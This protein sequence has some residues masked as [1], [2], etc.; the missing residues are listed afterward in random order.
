MKILLV[1][2]LY[3]RHDLS[4]II[5]PYYNKFDI[6]KLAVGSEGNVSREVAESSGWNYFESLNSPLTFKFTSLFQKAREYAPDAVLLMG[7]DDL[8]SER[9]I[10]YYQDNYSAEAK[11]LMGLKDLYFYHSRTG[12][13]IQHQ[14]FIGTKSPFTIGCG[15]IFS[16]ALLDTIDWKPWGEQRTERGL[17]ITCSRIFERIGV[18]E[19]QLTMDEAGMA[20]DIKTDVGLTKME[21]FNFNF[22]NVSAEII[23]KEFPEQLQ[24]I[25]NLYLHNDTRSLN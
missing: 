20:V 25:K 8:I 14:G 5:L 6:Q 2:A 21:T 1:T 7:S 9:L 4:K 3:Q 18:K 16:R 23:E 13:A 22:T 19:K 24:K 12:K 17:D 10:R 15:R 11:Y